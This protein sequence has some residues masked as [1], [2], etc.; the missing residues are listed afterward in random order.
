MKMYDPPHPGRILAESFTADF[1]LE[2]AARQLELEPS[3]LA[4]IVAGQAP[5]TP[6]IA[7][8]FSVIWPYFNPRTWLNMQAKYDAWQANRNHQWQEQVLARH[9]LS[10]ELLAQ[11]TA[12]E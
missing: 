2:D 5:I 10:P 12:W 7:F 11:R 8:L 6:E 4:A 3:E 1:T 9:H